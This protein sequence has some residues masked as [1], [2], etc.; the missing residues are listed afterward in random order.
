MA[1]VKHDVEKWGAQGYA[2]YCASNG[3]GAPVMVSAMDSVTGDL[4]IVSPVVRIATD[5]TGRM[6]KTAPSNIE[7]LTMEEFYKMVGVAPGKPFPE[8]V[9]LDN[10]QLKRIEDFRD[11]APVIDLAAFRA[12]RAAK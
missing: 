11:Y 6:F 4:V 12:A 1:I 10:Y 9:D 3:Y 5:G 2:F 8:P 7:P